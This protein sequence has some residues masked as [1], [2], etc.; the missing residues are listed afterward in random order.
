MHVAKPRSLVLDVYGGFI[1]PL[2]GWVAIAD[3]VELLHGLSL[4]DKAVRAATARLVDKGV[5]AREKRGGS[6]GYRLTREG[7]EILA[8]GDRRI[9]GLRRAGSLG[10]GWLIVFFTVPEEQRSQRHVLRSVLSWFGF[11]SLGPGTW[12]APRHRLDDLRSA[13]TRRQLTTYVDLITG[14][15]DGFD[16]QHSFV[17]R[18]W[19]LDALRHTYTE[20]LTNQRPAHERWRTRGEDLDDS[21]AFCDYLQLV[22]EWR[23]LSSIDPGL[24]AELLPPNWDGRAASDV[25]FDLIDWLTPRARRHVLT[26]VGRG[27]SLMS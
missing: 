9:F 14:H 2:G 10:D 7:E 27:L 12:V 1:R 11:G 18:C 21:A 15:Y 24:P 5:L 17:Q 19:D 4:D 6:S 25:Y 8:E 3:L 26:V 23:S 13:L 16:D 22:D 20:F